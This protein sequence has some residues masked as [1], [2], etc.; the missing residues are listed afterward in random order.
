LR[1][2][3]GRESVYT[4]GPTDASLPRSMPVDTYLEKQRWHLDYEKNG[5]LVDDFG[6][7][8]YGMMLGI[9]LASSLPL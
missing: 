6:V 2:P 5:Q 3:G 7:F 1:G 4:A 9:A 8:F